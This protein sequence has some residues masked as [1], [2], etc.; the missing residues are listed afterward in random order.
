MNKTATRKMERQERRFLGKQNN[1]EV[2]KASQTH[3]LEISTLK[4][5]TEPRKN[6]Y[7]KT[8]L[9]GISRKQPSI[10]HVEGAGRLPTNTI[11]DYS[12]VKTK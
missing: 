9:T 11:L 3:G 10:S 2:G 4:Q 5:P 6:T 7:S 1:L 12:K 8:K